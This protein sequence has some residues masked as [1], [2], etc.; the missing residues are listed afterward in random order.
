[1]EDKESVSQTDALLEQLFKTASL[2]HFLGRND[3]VMQAQSFQ[4]YLCSLCEEKGL[5]REHIIKRANL[6]RTYGHQ[7]FRGIKKPSRDKVI[8]LAFGFPLTVEET[9]KLLCIAGKS[10]LYPRL[11]R[12]AAILFCLNRRESMVE[13]QLLLHSLG[14]SQLGAE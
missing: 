12:D 2:S 10:P 14:L 7:I 4:N 5:V 1:M 13:V 3:G 11:K 8:Q 9:Q 6:D